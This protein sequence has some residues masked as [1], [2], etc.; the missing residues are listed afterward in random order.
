M[1]R[2]CKVALAPETG[3]PLY[4]KTCFSCVFISL[5]TWT[6]TAS[7]FIGPGDAICGGFEVSPERSFRPQMVLAHDASSQD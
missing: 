2:V 6:A 1:I 4:F 5:F 3:S 7:G